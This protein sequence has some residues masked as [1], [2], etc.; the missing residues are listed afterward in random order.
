MNFQRFYHIF[1]IQG[2]SKLLYN[3][4]YFQAINSKRSEAIK[5]LK[6]VLKENPSFFECRHNLALLLISSRKLEERWEGV[7]ELW[8]AIELNPEN[9]VSFLVFSY[10]VAKLNIRAWAFKKVNQLLGKAINEKIALNL[11]FFYEI[12]Q[13]ALLFKKFLNIFLEKI[14]SSEVQ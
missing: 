3:L 5:N 9:E 1:R 11:A 6:K 4:S 2:S 8:K 14:V 13:E 10:N 7:R 12:N